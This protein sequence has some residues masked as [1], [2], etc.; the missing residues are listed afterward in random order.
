LE[1]DDWQC[2][3]IRG[4]CSYVRRTK[5]GRQTRVLW[6]ISRYQKMYKVIDEESHTPRSS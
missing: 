1:P 4:T 6:E 5:Q 2:R 3:Y